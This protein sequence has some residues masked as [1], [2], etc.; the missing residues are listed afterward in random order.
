VGQPYHIVV[1]S[2]ASNL[3][4]HQPSL[5]TYFR[6]SSEHIS[7]HSVKTMETTALALGYELIWTFVTIPSLYDNTYNRHMSVY[8]TNR[9]RQK[10]LSASETI[11]STEFHTVLR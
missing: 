4:Q 8:L 11:T 5:V 1:M 9:A 7:N 10:L 2:Q 3:R 6:I